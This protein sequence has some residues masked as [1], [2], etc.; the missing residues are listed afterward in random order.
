[1]DD[2]DRIILGLQNRIRSLEHDLGARSL[3]VKMYVE[4]IWR[5][6]SYYNQVKAGTIKFDLEVLHDLIKNRKYYGFKFFAKDK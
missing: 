2:D 6:D 4:Q 1:M 3:S 5:L